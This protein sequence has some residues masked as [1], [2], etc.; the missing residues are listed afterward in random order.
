LHSEPESFIGD[1]TNPTGRIAGNIL[2]GKFGEDE[3][4]AAPEI[5]DVALQQRMMRRGKRVM[6][7]ICVLV[8]A[9]CTG[10]FWL[11][12]VVVAGTRSSMCG[13]IGQLSAPDCKKVSWEFVVGSISLGI[14]L[15]AV[16][17]MTCGVLFQMPASAKKR[18]NLR[19]QRRQAAGGDAANT[20]G[21]P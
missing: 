10:T 6:L 13:S 18:R 2:T 21:E 5:E 12:G 15:S 11:F 20:V 4:L 9:I 14:V 16:I 1:T 19:E 8:M 7:L 3:M 17:G